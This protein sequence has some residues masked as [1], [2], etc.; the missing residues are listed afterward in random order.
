M[1]QLHLSMPISNEGVPGYEPTT[2]LANLLSSIDDDPDITLRTHFRLD[3]ATVMF[4][5]IV[6]STAI[7]LR[8]GDEA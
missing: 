1:V 4:T 5:D 6:E 8:L 7:S 3:T 2:T